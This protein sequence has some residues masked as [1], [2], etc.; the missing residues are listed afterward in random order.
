MFDDSLDIWSVNVDGT[1]LR[2]L[3]RGLNPDPTRGFIARDPAWSP[4][5]RRIA[6][7]RSSGPG[8]GRLFVMAPTGAGARAVGRYRPDHD[9]S[10]PAWSPD[11]GRIAFVDLLF[12]QSDNP[13]WV[14]VINA[15]GSGL[16]KL[17]VVA[18]LLRS[19]RRM[20]RRSSMRTSSSAGQRCSTP[21][22]P[23]AG[24]NAYSLLTPRMASGRPTATG[25]PT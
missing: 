16:K 14:S 20:A 4:D 3:T 19:G 7:S 1:G 2:R 24:G 12:N 17:T 13:T 22:L 5:G 25:S 11:S 6:F 18:S 9:E 23:A 10:D 15:D 21:Y 8:E